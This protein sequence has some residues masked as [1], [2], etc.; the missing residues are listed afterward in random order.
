[1]SDPRN[2]PANGRVACDSLRGRVEADEFVSGVARQVVVPVADL[3]RAPNGPRDR[4]LLMGAELRVFED[5]DGWS[6][7]QAAA[8]GYCGY[9]RSEM[10]RA[11]SQ[12]THKVRTLATHAYAEPSFKS[13]DVMTLSFGARL[14]VDQVEGRFAKTSLGYVPA[15]HLCAV[16]DLTDDPAVIAAMFLGTPYLWGGNSRLG[17]DCSGLVQAALLACGIAC[18]GDSDQQESALGETIDDTPRRGDLLFWAGHVAM[19]VDEV[20]LI[21]ANAH[22]MAVAYEGI[23]DAK[24]RIEAQGDGRVTRHARLAEI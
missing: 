3:L 17:L 22:H 6:F 4:Q 1:M 21:H 20:T 18:P 11:Q 7:V 12:P 19:V 2:T 13:A 16:S 10:V 24:A 15:A 9:L 5:R 14:C 8:D 23:E